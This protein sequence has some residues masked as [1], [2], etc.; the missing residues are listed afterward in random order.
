MACAVPGG[1]VGAQLGKCDPACATPPCGTNKA[2]GGFVTLDDFEEPMPGVAATF[3]IHWRS[4]DGRTGSWRTRASTAAAVQLAIEPAGTG[5]ALDSKQALR[6]WG[7]PGTS[8]SAL[9]INVATCYDASA[10]EGVSLWLKGNPA[11][12]NTQIRFNV[13]T[14]VTEPVASG[15]VCTA[16][17]GLHFAKVL[18]VTPTWVRHKIPW[19]DL[20]LT[21][22]APTVPPVPAKFDPQK[23]ILT[24]S[25]ETL[26]GGKGFDFS[27]DDFTFD[28]DTKVVATFADVISEATYKELFRSALPVYTYEGLVMATT[29]YGQNQFARAGT[30]LDRKHEAVAFLSHIAKE[31][32]GLSAVRES[33]CAP[34]MTPSCTTYNTAEQNYFGRG[35][36]QLTH[37][38]NYDAAN[39]TFAGISANPDLVATNPNYA[40]GTGI[41]FWMVRGCHTQIMNKNF[42]GT[43]RIIN[44]GVECGSNPLRPMGAPSRVERYKEFGAAVGINPRGTLLC[45]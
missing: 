18:D 12:G 9:S 38:A 45:P 44:G 23:M 3:P 36:M 2:T 41:W 30:P 37:K 14:P 8:P 19:A 33:A 31:T 35:C 42:G 17:C 7:G 32:G 39:G 22:C 4:R 27:I 40:F 24:F 25:L 29:L 34:V 13:H 1:Y 43:T 16:N 10:Y 28:L 21:A 5:T 15:G 20:R 6:F 11:A 26:D